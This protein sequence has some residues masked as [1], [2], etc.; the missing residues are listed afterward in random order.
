MA[1][2]RAAYE[3][4]L[5]AE[6]DLAAARGEPYAQVIDIDPRW[7]AG[8]PLPHLLSN[9]SRAFVVCR[10]DQPDPDWDGTYATVVSPAD[11]H[12]S[13]LVVLELR[14]CREIRSAGQTTRR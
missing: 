3:Q 4:Q 6:R 12:P 8:A 7:D 9:G 11:P 5:Q 10:A 13:L 1:E 14:G 2:W